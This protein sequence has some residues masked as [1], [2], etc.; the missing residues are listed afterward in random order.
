MSRERH[1]ALTGWALALATTA[2]GAQDKAGDAL[3]AVRATPHSRVEQRQL[4][5]HALGR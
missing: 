1:A 5:K 4:R 2:A 3:G